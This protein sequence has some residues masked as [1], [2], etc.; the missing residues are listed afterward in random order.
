MRIVLLAGFCAM[1]TV[2]YF[3]VAPGERGT[4]LTVF[5][6]LWII[7]F[8][9]MKLKPNPATKSKRIEIARLGIRIV[10]SNDDVMIYW[11]DFT[12]LLES[13]RLFVLLAQKEAFTLT[14]P[15]RVFPD[16]ASQDF[17]RTVARAEI[18][19]CAAVRK[20]GSLEP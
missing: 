3:Q 15:K 11:L 8:S 13:E 19:R 10:R 20:S 5:I 7:V 14:L 6:A 1:A 18:S 2:F 9:W 4:W 17:F 12:K 16:T